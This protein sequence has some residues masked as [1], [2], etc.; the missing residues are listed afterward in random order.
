VGR[1][2][3]RAD[4][5]LRCAR[6]PSYA[7]T[8]VRRA[9]TADKVDGI[10]ASKKPRA[11]RLLP[12]DRHAKLPASVLPRLAA[13][14]PGE[15]GEQG[16]PGDTGQQGPTGETGAKGEKGDT[17]ATGAQGDIGPSNSYVASKSTF[18][19]STTSTIGETALM[20]NLPA[21]DYV[22]TASGT[23]YSGGAYNLVGSAWIV[24]PTET[25]Y[26]YNGLDTNAH[27]Y[28]AFSINAST[29]LTSPGSVR[30]VTYKPTASDSFAL[31]YATLTATKVGTVTNQ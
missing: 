22:V 27:R 5:R 20:L 21:G 7:G 29:R 13:G 19:A 8:I 28:A 23:M 26:V 10:H 15:P 3:G 30:L 1:D 31:Y 9:V 12:L 17:G 2:R 16:E 14:Q 24:T 6:G 11:G 25:R 18:Y 4:R